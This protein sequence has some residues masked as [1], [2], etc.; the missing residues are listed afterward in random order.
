MHVVFYVEI[1]RM[2][3]GRNQEKTEIRRFRKACVLRAVDSDGKR[4][5]LDLEIVPLKVGY[6]CT[7]RG[8]YVPLRLTHSDKSD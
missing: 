2:W 4:V 5:F 3:E 7:F 8:H 1:V 6:F